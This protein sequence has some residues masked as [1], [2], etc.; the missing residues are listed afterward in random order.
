MEKDLGTLETGKLADLVIVAGDPLHDIKAAA[1]VQ[2][3]M[4]NGKL[5]SVAELMAPFAHGSS[6]GAPVSGR[7]S[8]KQ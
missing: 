4:K 2:Y 8:L 1:N 3:V 6:D 5:Y 7:A